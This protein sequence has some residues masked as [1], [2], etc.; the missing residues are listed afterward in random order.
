MNEKE[1]S[2]EIK[3]NDPDTSDLD[4]RFHHFYK[5]GER[6]EVV[7]KEG[8]ELNMCY[9]KEGGQVSRFYVG[10]STGWRPVYLMIPRKDSMGGMAILSDAVE[11]VRGLGIY[12]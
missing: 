2:E 7:W 3:S 8:Y 1:I 11:S 12:R 5:S 6:V 4:P 9:P 10:K